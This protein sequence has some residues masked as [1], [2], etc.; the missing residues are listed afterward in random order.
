MDDDR[1]CVEFH[2]E[3]TLRIVTDAAQRLIGAFNSHDVIVINCDNITSVDLSF[4]QVLLSARKTARVQNKRVFLK[5]RASGPLFACLQSAG[6][7]HAAI[8]GGGTAD[9]QFW[10]NGVDADVENNPHG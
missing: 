7:L 1:T 4:I 3:Q 9:L 2:G 8:D 5:N 10:M 6:L